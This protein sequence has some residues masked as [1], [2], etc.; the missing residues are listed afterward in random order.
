MASQA[1]T[2]ERERERAQRATSV[3]HTD[4]YGYA[5]RLAVKK[6]DAVFAQAVSYLRSSGPSPLIVVAPPGKPN[7]D[8][9][10]TAVGVGW[11][12]R[13]GYLELFVCIDKRSFTPKRMFP[14]GALESAILVSQT[15]DF[16][17][18]YSGRRHR[19]VHKRE[20]VGGERFGA[21]K[22]QVVVEMHR[23]ADLIRPEEVTGLV[24]FGG[25]YRF[26][27]SQARE[28]DGTPEI[29]FDADGLPWLV[30]VDYDSPEI[31]R[32]DEFAARAAGTL[33]AQN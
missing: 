32:L 19:R 12:L 2:E 33:A 17:D 23:T 7:S 27:K 3:R 31:M 22:D 11:H 4:E 16:V 8:E 25:A 20:L 9:P 26:S 10:R 13:M 29:C 21:H 24:S 28:S 30:A 5:H 18:R 15:I 1:A 14:G 6:I